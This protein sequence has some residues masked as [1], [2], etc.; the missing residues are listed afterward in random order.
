MIFSPVIY[1]YADTGV[2]DKHGESVDVIIQKIREKQG[3]GSDE[4]IDPRNVSNADL[5]KLGEAVMSIMHPDSEQHG[6]MD[7]MMGGEGSKSLSSMHQKMGYS[8]I[9][10]DSRGMMGDS[11]MPMIG[12]GMMGRSMMGNRFGYFSY[13]WIIILLLTL[14]IIGVIL[15]LVIRSQKRLGKI[16]GTYHEPPLMIAQRRY[17]LGEITKEEY[18]TIKQDLK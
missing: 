13:G 8:Y 15:Y 16:G 14:I 1:L 6:L 5:E 4:N 7:N 11:F 17:A 9:R 12:G 10:G 3:L 18:E 2:D